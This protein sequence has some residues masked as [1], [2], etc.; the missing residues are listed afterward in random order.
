[1][2]V[3]VADSSEYESESPLIG[4]LKPTFPLAAVLRARLEKELMLNGEKVHEV[5]WTRSATG[6]I[7]VFGAQGKELGSV[8]SIEARK[9]CIFSSVMFA[10]VRRETQ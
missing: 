1:M 2:V 3:Q 10:R 5:L 9:E 7:R 6:I 4:R 8:H